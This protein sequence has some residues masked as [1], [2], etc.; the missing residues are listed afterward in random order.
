MRTSLNMRSGRGALRLDVTGRETG[1]HGQRL[2]VVLMLHWSGHLKGL[3]L[4]AQ[5]QGARLLRCEGFATSAKIAI[6]NGSTRYS[7]I[8]E[9][10]PCSMY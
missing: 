8:C 3:S 9:S 6:R 7:V 5:N 4:T 10:L 1:V 2:V